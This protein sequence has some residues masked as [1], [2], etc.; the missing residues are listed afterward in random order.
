MI[1]HYGFHELFYASCA[2]KLPAG[3]E[4]L[5]RIGAIAT[6]NVVEEAMDLSGC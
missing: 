4:V 1:V 6:K 5:E 3:L 2:E